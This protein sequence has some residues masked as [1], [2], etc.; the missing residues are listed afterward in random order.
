LKRV[1]LS[2]EKELFISTVHCTYGSDYIFNGYSA[3]LNEMFDG[4][5]QSKIS[6]A[7]I[8]NEDFES[9]VVILLPNNLQR[10]IA[11][12]SITSIRKNKEV[13]FCYEKTSG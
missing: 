1:Y 5:W 3:D 13:Y 2:Q 9:E 7:N 11:I 10:D 8:S 4:G 12:N 6:Y